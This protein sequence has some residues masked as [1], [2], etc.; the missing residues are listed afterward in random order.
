MEDTEC[1]VFTQ[2]YNRLEGFT[3]C[4]GLELF[5]LKKSRQLK[6]SNMEILLN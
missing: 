4:E 3:D 6:K 5:Q 1:A 2:L